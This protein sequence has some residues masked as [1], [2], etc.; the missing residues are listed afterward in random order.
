[1]IKKASSNNY[2]AVIE[3]WELSVRATHDFLP[4]DYLRHIKTLLPSILPQVELYIEENAAGM[5]RGFLGVADRKMEMLFI[6]PDSRG[7]GIGKSLLRFAVDHLAVNKV[8]VNEQN[9]KAVDFYK[10]MG[11]SIVSRTETDGLGKPFPLLEMEF[12]GD[13][14]DRFD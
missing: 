13:Q 8:D 2:P 11:F 4:E 7:Q 10:K 1:M 14:P 12:T 9:E 3:L 5:I 6:H